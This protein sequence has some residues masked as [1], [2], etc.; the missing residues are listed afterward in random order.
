MVKFDVF[1]DLKHISVELNKEIKN[2]SECIVELYEHL[3]TFKNTREVH[4]EA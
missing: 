3:V 4:G 2:A 1:Q